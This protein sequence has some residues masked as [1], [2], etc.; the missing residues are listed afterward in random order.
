MA[1]SRP[2]L[3]SRW[4]ASAK[5]TEFGAA[6]MV[7][8]GNGS[9]LNVWVT[10]CDAAPMI[11]TLSLLVFVTNT[12]P[13][14]T[15]SE[16]GCRPTLIV[17]VTV[18]LARFTTDTV[19]VVDAPVTGSDTIGVLLVPGPAKWESF[20]V[21][22]ALAGRPSRFDTNASLPTM[23]MASGVLPTGILSMTWFVVVS[24]TPSRLLPPNVAYSVLPSDDTAIRLGYSKVDS[25]MTCGELGFVIK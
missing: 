8:P 14:C 6:P 22:P 1:L 15:V 4:R 17:S 13:S 23:A 7:E 11:D 10:L 5:A 12:E 24:I 16:A 20:V 19:P 2:T 18:L 3:T 25:G 21:S 9:T